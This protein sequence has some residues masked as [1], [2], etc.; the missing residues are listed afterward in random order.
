[1]KLYLSYSTL[2]QSGSV[3]LS[4][5]FPHFNRY[6][7]QQMDQQHFETPFQELFV[8]FAFPPPYVLPLDTKVKDKFM[9]RYA[10]LPDYNIHRTLKKIVITMAAPELSNYFDRAEKGN[11]HYRFFITNDPQKREEIKLAQ[12]LLDKLVETVEY[13]DSKARPSDSFAGDSLIRL[14]LRIKSQLTLE[15]F[16]GT[17]AEASGTGQDVLL[18]QALLQRAHRWE[19]R[20]AQYQMIRDL[21]VCYVD[22][23]A[24]ALYPYDYQYTEIFLN[25]LSRKG[26]LCPDY[27]HIYIHVSGSKEAALRRSVPVFDWYTYGVANVDYESYLLQSPEE[28]EK[29][30]L[31]LICAGLLDIAEIDGLDLGLI[32]EAIREVRQKGLNTE[33]LYRVVEHPRY[34]LTITYL[35]RSREEECP[36]FFL[37]ENKA[38]HRKYL[39][40][41]GRADQ[42]QLHLWLHTIRL[43]QKYIKVW[44]STSVQAEAW[45]EGKK[46]ELVF[47]VRALMVPEY[48]V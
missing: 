32:N 48:E 28:Q 14:L 42:S 22:L 1:M 8:T 9:E 33:L 3:R 6:I 31:D 17:G 16:A 45:L 11:D 20:K 7:Q 13:I 46:T 39:Q 24:R 47:S 37:V 34:T 26:L 25:V 23:P 15:P 21:R 18:H 19:N 43:S 2:D 10:G 41:I 5:N 35:A 30:V 29:T 27:H 12:T 4:G 44:S 36:V 38:T 40:Q